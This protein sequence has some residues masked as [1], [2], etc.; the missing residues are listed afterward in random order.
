MDKTGQPSPMMPAMVVPVES[1]TQ[2]NMESDKGGNILN[3]NG[4]SREDFLGGNQ[5]TTI[6][7]EKITIY[8]HGAIVLGIKN[9]SHQMYLFAKHLRETLQPTSFLIWCVSRVLGS[10]HQ[11][12]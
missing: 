2:Q 9:Q 12:G 7:S 6:F 8:E 4:I 5:V 3:D 11:I 1:F 10:A